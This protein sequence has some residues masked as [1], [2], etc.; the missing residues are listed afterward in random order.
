[1]ITIINNI[2]VGTSSINITTTIP[3]IIHQIWI[4]GYDKIPDSLKI[5]HNGCKSTNDNFKFIF[6]DEPRI[7]KLLLK[8]FG[9]KYVDA[10]DT[11]Q[12]FAQKSD[13]ARYAI[14]YIYGGIYLDMD[15]I[16]RKNLTPFLNYNFFCTTDSIYF[17]ILSKKYLNGIMGAKKKHPVFPFIFKN[18]FE[19]L[20]DSSYVLYSTGPKLLYDAVTDYKKTTGMDDITVIDRKYLHPCITY[21]D[22]SC[23]YTC[24]DCYI[25]HTN[26]GSWGT[27]YSKLFNKYIVR[28]LKV[29]LVIVALFILFIIFRSG[30]FR[31]TKYM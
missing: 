8:Y 9:K 22:D 23:P 6:W 2:M 30:L 16:C 10:Y 7:K 1:M 11:Y 26:Y 28:N 19:R 12:I 31:S 17:F 24:N 15:M 25:A 18:M 20:L 13:F 21:D 29:I 5:L 27:S 14:L 3:P 4:Q